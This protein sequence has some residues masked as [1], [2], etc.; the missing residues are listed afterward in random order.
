[1]SHGMFQTSRSSPHP[2]HF[3]QRSASVCHMS[4]IISQTSSSGVWSLQNPQKSFKRDQ[5][6]H[7][8]VTHNLSYTLIL[9]STRIWPR[10]RPQKS[11]ASRTPLSALWYRLFTE[12]CS[13]ST[14]L[15]PLSVDE[16]LS[17]CVSVRAHVCVC[18][19][20]SVR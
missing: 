1:M 13:S 7:T 15:L 16:S 18:A 19:R 4:A 9:N 5:I 20:A 14:S 10:P 8:E 6:S 11:G 2:S 3:D 17:V 12:H